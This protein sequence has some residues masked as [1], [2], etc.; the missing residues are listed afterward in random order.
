VLHPKQSIGFGNHVQ[1]IASDINIPNIVDYHNSKWWGNS[2]VPIN[3][4][5]IKCNI[6]RLEFYFCHLFKNFTKHL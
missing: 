6:K 3:A 1:E 2:I 5:P 4:A